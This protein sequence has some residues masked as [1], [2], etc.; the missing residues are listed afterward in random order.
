MENLE[1]GKN[2]LLQAIDRDDFKCVEILMDDFV[3]SNFEE[4]EPIR[5]ALLRGHEKIAALLA[6]DISF[7]NWW[8]LKVA[9][10]KNLYHFVDELI[11]SS[12]GEHQAQMKKK[13][14]YYA[15]SEG[16]KNMAER[17][18]DDHQADDPY[19]DNFP[20]GNEDYEDDSHWR[21]RELREG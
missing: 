6:D 20:A 17:L 3:T 7:D 9:A 15:F 21:N 16:N 10:V 1:F 8:C 14:L 13:A 5:A 12:S 2:E 11:S 19:G 4:N 18:I